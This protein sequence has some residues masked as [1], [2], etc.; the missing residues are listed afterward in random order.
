M[1]SLLFVTIIFSSIYGYAFDHSHKAFTEILSKHVSYSGIGGAESKVNYKALLKDRGPLNAYIKTIEAVKKS[2]FDA[3]SPK[4][5]LA[6]LINTYN[7]HTIKLILDNYPTKS[8]LKVTFLSPFWKKF[9]NLFG[10]EVSLEYVE[11]TLIRKVFFEKHYV[12]PMIHFAVNCAAIGCPRLRNE[13]FVADKLEVQFEEQAKLFLRD[14]TRI[15]LDNEKKE[16]SVSLIFTKF[17][18]DWDKSKFKGL[19]PYLAVYMTDDP[20]IQASLKK[21]EFKIV[22]R[23]YN[24]DLNEKK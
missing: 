7:A 16:L 13:A 10:D 14:T 22:E 5:Q 24:W 9:I 3:F 12:E 15:G 18:E 1:R 4:Q 2:D 21:K 6:F 23:D 11:H 17:A 20:A 19:Q 8:I